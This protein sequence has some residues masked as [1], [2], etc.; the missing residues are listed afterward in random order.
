M[1]KLF[2]TL[3]CF[4]A[5]LMKAQIRTTAVPRPI[6]GIIFK[7]DEAGNQI[8]RGHHCLDCQAQPLQNVTETSEE[9]R[10]SENSEE[11]F[12]REINIYPVP[13]KDVLTIVW[14]DK[15]ENLIDEVSL[16]EQNTIHWKFQQ[17]NIPNLNK[18]IQINMTNYYMGVYVL[19]FTLKD[20]RTLSKNITKF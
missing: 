1:K 8:Y 6:G 11:S 20:G 16:Y 14:T 19:I 17:Q 13:V 2:F 18:Q 10:I 12:W 5:L 15:V 7:Y 3:T 4:S 9:N